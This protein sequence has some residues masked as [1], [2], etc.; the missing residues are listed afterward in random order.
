MNQ[1]FKARVKF[2]RYVKLTKDLAWSDMFICFVEQELRTLYS[3]L[4]MLQV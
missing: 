4:D 2:F 1:V 3:F